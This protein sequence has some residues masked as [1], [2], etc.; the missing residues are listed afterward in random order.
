MVSKPLKVPLERP[1]KFGPFELDKHERELRCNG[2]RIDLKGYRY[3]ILE[4][5]IDQRHQTVSK[6]DLI[7]AVWAPGAQSDDA[8]V[9]QYIHLLR[10]ALE[11]NGPPG[12][13][14]IL[15]KEKGF[16]FQ[17]EPHLTPGVRASGSGMRRSR[18]AA[19]TGFAYPRAEWFD[20][21]SD[22]Q[23]TEL[24][25][26]AL[27]LLLF[28][29]TDSG[30]WGKT[31][32]SRRRASNEGVPLARGSLG[33]T[34]LAMIAIGSS[35]SDPSPLRGSFSSAL[36]ETLAKLLVAERGRYRRGLAFSDGGEF[37]SWE[38]GR[39]TAGALLTRL[40]LNRDKAVD[41]K[42]VEYLCDATLDDMSWEKAIVARALA[43]A[44]TRRTTPRILKSRVRVRIGV[45][46][47]DLSA[48]PPDRTIAHLWADRYTYGLDVNNQWGTAF[49]ML[50]FIAG[51]LPSHGAQVLLAEALRGFLLAQAASARGGSSLLASNV[52][53][54]GKGSGN[55]VF[56]TAIAVVAWRTLQL[57]A[58]KPGE[59]EEAA[60]HARKMVNRL[61]SNWND[62]LE[63]PSISDPG[64]RCALEGYLAWAGLLLA[65]ASVGTRIAVH[66]LEEAMRL[67][68]K[69]ELATAA[70]GTHELN[71]TYTSILADSGWVMSESIPMVARS[72]VRISQL[73]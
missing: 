44:E 5:L 17:Y 16:K 70:H 24:A 41:R 42:T 4:H 69:L 54:S 73:P 66:E 20:V 23:L 37:P 33:G 7:E 55:Y 36:D 72:L 63:I 68:S 43:Q 50:P 22:E 51:A 14:Y 62:S 18:L 58:P 65:T 13:T 39:H 15:T 1:Y 2:K 28:D 32:L 35:L 11:K 67:T 56:G 53:P 38:P 3:K 57:F 9:R 60:L 29:R 61:L 49:W 52:D 10:K 45:L 27:I 34:P 6:N 71:E 48:V 26:A 8:K 59:R 47:R 19:L 64:N 21:P 46:L 25:K 31:Y 12:A 40:L 30:C